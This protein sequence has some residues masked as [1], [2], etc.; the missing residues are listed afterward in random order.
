MRIEAELP[1]RTPY[2]PDPFDGNNRVLTLAELE[3]YATI[4]L[5]SIVY[6]NPISA[7]YNMRRPV[8][9]AAAPISSRVF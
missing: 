9:S 1:D 3:R 5:S 8:A 4:T 7:T 2:A 6:D